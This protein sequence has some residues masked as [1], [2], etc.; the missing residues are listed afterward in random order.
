MGNSHTIRTSGIKNRLSKTV[1]KIVDDK[2]LFYIFAY[3]FENHPN[4][5]KQL[6]KKINPDVLETYIS[7]KDN[8]NPRM[9]QLLN[10]GLEEWD[11]N[12][13]MVYLLVSYSLGGLNDYI[14]NQ[15]FINYPPELDIVRL[16]DQISDSDIKGGGGFNLVGPVSFYYWPS[17]FISENNKNVEILI[18]GD[19]HSTLDFNK[20]KTKL[21][22]KLINQYYN[23]LNAP[24]SGSKKSKLMH[25]LSLGKYGY[26]NDMLLWDWIIQLMYQKKKRNFCVDFFTESNPFLIGAFDKSFLQGTT[27]IF[28]HICNIYT[29]TDC[30]QLTRHHAVD[31][32]KLIYSD[33]PGM[34]SYYNV[35]ENPAKMITIQK[36]FKTV[37]HFNSSGEYK[38][39]WGGIFDWV[40]SGIFP[41]VLNNFVKT[42]EDIFKS[43][44]TKYFN[45]L[46]KNR[47]ISESENYKTY[48]DDTPMSLILAH[49]IR[50]IRKQYLKSIFNSAE[51]TERLKSI[52]I[53]FT[54]LYENKGYIFSTF[55]LIMDLYNLFRMFVQEDKISDKHT[56]P[57]CGK[58]SP[59]HIM[60]YAGDLHIQWL[61]IIIKKYFKIHPSDFEI[62]S[63][64]V[65]T[66]KI[67]PFTKLSAKL[68]A[69]L[70]F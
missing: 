34:A 64:R 29:N 47:K 57:S 6:V 35:I 12:T 17:I 24:L 42:I 58:S 23:A 51:K 28:S 14:I 59:T 7:H 4:R 50:L 38:V 37:L 8:L 70:G 9:I 36:T 45:Y 48:F 26:S 5:I 15:Y 53:K 27:N 49:Q 22:P 68:S 54:A 25:K 10:G 46:V 60:F 39:I 18:M 62:Q 52:I 21:T 19:E 1:Q 43:Y 69:K 41:D 44:L 3:D 65:V 13:V 20:S 56:H 61:Y 33:K 63:D 31:I 30:P 32:R 67:K 40:V 2:P 55:I 16:P 11:I 66:M